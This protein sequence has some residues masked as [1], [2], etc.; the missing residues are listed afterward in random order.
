MA[1]NP[2]IFGNPAAVG[3]QTA[4]GQMVIAGGSRTATVR[5]RG[6]KK[7]IR[8]RSA[9]PAK[10]RVMRAA[11]R[12]TRGRSKRLARLVKGSAAAKRYMASIRRKRR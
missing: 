8:R 4:V 2:F 1:F 12:R 5:R 7:A 6:K 11:G 9:K 3:Q 10:R